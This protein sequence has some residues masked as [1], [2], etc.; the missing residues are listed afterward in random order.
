MRVNGAGCIEK[1]GRGSYR[2]RFSLGKNPLTG[3]Y[4]YSPW[5]TVRGNKDDVRRASEEY[6]REIEGGLR[7]DLQDTTFSEF[8]HVFM[9]ERKN[10]GTLAEAT[11]YG[12]RTIINKY[13]NKYLGEIPMVEIS[14]QLLK[15]V[16][17]RLVQDDGVSQNRLHEIVMKTKHILREAVIADIIIRSPADKIKTPAKPKPIRHSLKK[18]E[19]SR[20]FSAVESCKLDRNTIALYIGIVTG[21][22]R[23]EVL[24]LRWS[25]I[26][27]E[28]MSLRVTHA[29]DPK[30]NM[31]EPKSAAGMRS[32]SLDA[33]TC[34]KLREWKKAQTLWLRG[35]KATLSEDTFVCSNRY[36]EVCQPSRFYGWFKEFCVA[37]DFAEWVDV[38]G[39]PFP[40][41]RFNENGH[42]IDENGRCYTRTNKRP[43]GRRFY[44]GLKFHELRHTHATLLIAN[45]VDIKTVQTRLGHSKA[46]MTLD[47][48]AHAQEEQDRRA[49][50]LFSSLV[51]S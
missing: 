40:K 8:T 50:D 43:K 28:D 29:L 3:K 25:N 36:G 30:R 21:M 11:L 7:L 48:Y 9:E 35:Y 37:N 23:G 32:I 31:K 27:L 13:L 22:R 34:A 6:R 39:T 12:E 41:R 16:F 14:T 17:I 33:I 19:A 18:P 51:N 2:V 44:R 42:P 38:N 4:E 5:R 26:D 45:G 49:V 15:E 20:L 1:R 10:L 24:A 47:F 46:A